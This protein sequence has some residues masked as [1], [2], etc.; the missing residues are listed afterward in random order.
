MKELKV[1]AFVQGHWH[2]MEHVQEK[3]LLREFGWKR[4]LWYAKH[5]FNANLKNKTK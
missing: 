2:T 3:K 5:G 4:F 1:T